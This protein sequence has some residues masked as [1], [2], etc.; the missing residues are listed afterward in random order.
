MYEKGH[1]RSDFRKKEEYLLEIKQKQKLRNLS[2][3]KPKPKIP[4]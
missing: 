1:L 3:N 2:D 4:K